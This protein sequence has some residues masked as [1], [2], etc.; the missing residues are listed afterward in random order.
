MWPT[1]YVFN[2]VAQV[3]S[4][5]MVIRFHRAIPLPEFLLFPLL[6]IC[7]LSNQVII[8]P[9]FGAIQHES[10]EVLRSCRGMVRVKQ[11]HGEGRLFASNKLAEKKLKGLSPLQVRLGPF[12]G[13]DTT[14]LLDVINSVVCLTVNA[15]LM[16]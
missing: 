15:V 2:I 5:F 4:L 8:F 12:A 6:F 10:K 14:T 9:P 13:F 11:I 1:F 7:W 16:S 3:L